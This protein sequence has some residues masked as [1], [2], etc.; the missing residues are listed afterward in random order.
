MTSRNFFLCF[1]SVICL[2][3]FSVSSKAESAALSGVKMRNVQNI[4]SAQIAD[5]SSTYLNIPYLWGGNDPLGFDCSGFINYLF[6]NAGINVPRYTSFDWF[7]KGNAIHANSLLRGDLVFFHTYE[8]LEAPNPATHIGIYLGDGTFVS[9]TSSK[10]IAV[11][12]LNLPY[13]SS[14]YI[15]AK[16]ISVF[17]FSK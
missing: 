9:A 13:W 5:Q 15:G 10:G 6:Q 16:R 2:F 7:Q 1:L 11:Y 17:D 14:K 12:P 8:D 4:L 3:V